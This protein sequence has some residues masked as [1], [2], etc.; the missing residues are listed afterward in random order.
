MSERAY[1]QRNNDHQRAVAQREQRA[2]KAGEP[3]LR[4]RVEPGETVNRS[5]MIRI[6]AVSH[7]KPEDHQ[8]EGA[9]LSRKLFD[10]NS[11]LS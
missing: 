7:A 3:R 11:P 6:Q 2:A 5:E 4:L 10:H 9:P 1:C 8:A